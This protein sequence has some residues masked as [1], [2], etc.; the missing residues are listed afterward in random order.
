MI[1]FNVCKNL[2]LINWSGH[3]ETCTHHLKFASV[4]HL[5]LVQILFHSID[6]PILQNT[7]RLHYSSR[8]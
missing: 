1:Y 5:H 4:D 7:R 3:T 2:L 8:L 6:L